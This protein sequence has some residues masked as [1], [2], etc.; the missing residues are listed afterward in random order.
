[1]KSHR[2]FPAVVLLA[3]SAAAMALAA[4]QVEA[5]VAPTGFA[6][7]SAAPS[8]SSAKKSALPFLEDD[9]AAALKQAQERH[10]P[11]FVDAWA[12]WCHSCRSMKEFVLS[13][14][15]LGRRSAQFVWLS[16]D[17]EKPGNEA[18]RKRLQ[19]DALPTFFIL[20]PQTGDAALRWIG[21]GT[22]AQM[23]KFLDD[24]RRAVG[25]KPRG[26]EATLARGEHAFAEGRKSEAVTLY[27]EA[28]AAAPAGWPQYG[29]ALES[30]LFALSSTRDTAGCART[31]SGAW[32]RLEKTPSAANVAASGLS[33]ADRMS[34]TEPDQGKL[35]AELRRATLEVVHSGRKDF[36]ADDISSAYFTLESDRERAGDTAGKMALLREHAAFLDRAAERAGTA[37]RRAVFDS[38]RLEVSIDLGEPERAVA[39]LQQAEKDLPEDYNPPARLSYA[40]TAM[41]KYDDAA[42]ASDRALVRAYGPRRILILERRAD[43]E[44]HRGD[45]AASRRFLQQAIS[46]AEALP[47]GQREAEEIASL[48]KK[49]EE[50]AGN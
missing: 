8:P 32:A 27:R 22:V 7:V 39:M 18:L 19:I 24:G 38:H 30:L 17:T 12:T 10:V 36:A 15:S 48:K 37:E 3:A 25:G 42:A 45:A 14:P 16:L 26:V 21:G 47:A 44:T 43:I 4:N 29:R 34:P 40:Y 33:C 31:A 6:A 35:V 28:L 23:H 46:E 20:D 1:M 2:P 50:P 41:K 49:L 5:A 9:Y 13:D 11:I